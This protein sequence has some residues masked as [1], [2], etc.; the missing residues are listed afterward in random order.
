M[1]MCPKVNP[2]L[3]HH[4]DHWLLQALAAEVVASKLWQNQ[5]HFNLQVTLTSIMIRVFSMPLILS[6]NRQPNPITGMNTSRLRP[7]IVWSMGST[8]NT[9][10]CN[11]TMLTKVKQLMMIPTSVK[12]RCC[13]FRPAPPNHRIFFGVS[14][15]WS[16]RIFTMVMLLM[17][18][19]WT[20]LLVP[21]VPPLPGQ[22]IFRITG[23]SSRGGLLP[24]VQVSGKKDERLHGPACV[25]PICQGGPHHAM[26]HHIVFVCV[27]VF[28]Y[29]YLYLYL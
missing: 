21:T 25:P 18:I 20:L 27:C 15:T 29:L 26:F 16:D 23:R 9:L 24:F 12:M 17:M 28:L 22:R 10:V 14:F 8:F 3:Y 5:N 2:M 13:W 7:S 19:P 11:N 6:K 1:L 4:I